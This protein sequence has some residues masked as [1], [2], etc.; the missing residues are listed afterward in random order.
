MPPG[1]LQSYHFHAR[2]SDSS[3]LQFYNLVL[4]NEFCE[5]VTGNPD[6]SPIS[7]STELLNQIQNLIEGSQLFKLKPKYGPSSRCTGD[8]LW[9]FEAAFDSGERICSSGSHVCPYQEKLKE[10]AECIDSVVTTRRV[11]MK[12]KGEIV[13]FYCYKCNSEVNSV[14]SF[15]AK[16]TKDGNVRLTRKKANVKQRFIVKEAFAVL[17]E[18]VYQAGLDM[19]VNQTE[20]EIDVCDGTTWHYSGTFVDGTKLS[21]SGN[22]TSPRGAALM[23]I[24]TYFEKLTEN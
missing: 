7:V 15:D 12:R 19:E 13:Q 24:F 10:I 22:D 6:A 9:S 8:E 16:K 23:N 3:P 2:A 21:Y 18:I 1:Q 11:E 14:Y 5:A 17:T 20:E 4:A